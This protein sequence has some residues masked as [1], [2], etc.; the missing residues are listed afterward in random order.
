MNGVSPKEKKS[1][2]FRFTSYFEKQHT[3]SQQNTLPV[4]PLEIMDTTELRNLFVIK[5]AAM[6][7]GGFVRGPVQIEAKEGL[8]AVGTARGQLV[9]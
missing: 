3:K 7:C 9:A 5:D 2:A 6:S 4:L 1:L 8:A